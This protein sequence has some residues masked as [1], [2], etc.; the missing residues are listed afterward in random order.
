MIRKEI[1]GTGKSIPR[2]RVVGSASGTA[3]EAW[4]VMRR[5]F[6]LIEVMVVTVVI[7]IL[8]AI[9]VK[10]IGIGDVSSRRNTTISRLQRMENALS[11]YFAA[12][13]SYPPVATLY[14]HNVYAHYNETDDSQSGENSGLVWEDVRR[15]CASQPVAARFPFPNDDTVRKYIEMLSVEAVNRANGNDSQFKTWQNYRTKLGGG[16]KP[17]DSPNDLKNSADWKSKEKTW[18]EVKVFQFG[19]MSFLLPRYVFITRCVGNKSDSSI[20]YDDL[21]DCGQWTANN[22]FSSHPNTG[23]QFGTWRQQLEDKR[24]V[25]RI[26]SQSICARWMPNFEGIVSGNPIK[27]ENMKFFGINVSDGE[28]ALDLEDPAELANSVYI[29][30]NR[31]VL[32]ILTVRDGWRREFYYYSPPPYQSYRLWSAGADGKTFPP[33]IPLSTLKNDADRKTA[34][35]WMADDIMYLNK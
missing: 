15:V 18:P 20:S 25:R 31:T 26:P 32:D 9:S 13:G 7:S 35:N 27:E 24:L 1:E 33:W 28:F 12:F 3:W 30:Q 17:F 5:A 8:L 21:D 23:R 6:T 16:F 4:G 19:L 34:A 10:I 29:E 2:G 14:S 11:G 22:R